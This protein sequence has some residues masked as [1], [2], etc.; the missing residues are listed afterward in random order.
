MIG[1]HYFVWPGTLKSIVRSVYNYS[2][3][4]QKQYAVEFKLRWVHHYLKYKL[5]YLKLVYEILFN[6]RKTYELKKPCSHDSFF[7]SWSLF[8]L[9][10]CVDYSCNALVWYLFNPIV[11]RPTSWNAGFLLFYVNICKSLS[12]VSQRSTET[13]TWPF[14]FVYSNECI[15]IIITFAQRV[16]IRDYIVIRT[17]PRFQ[18]IQN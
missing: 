14:F 2:T 9:G 17:T 5:G 7:P 18:W 10:F 3:F 4:Y 16:C 12:C 6:R 15:N 1:D 8:R 13:W 11:L